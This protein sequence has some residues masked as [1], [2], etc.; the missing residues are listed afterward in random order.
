VELLHCSFIGLDIDPTTKRSY[1]LTEKINCAMALKGYSM[2]NLQFILYDVLDIASLTEKEYFSKHNR[3]NFDVMLEVAEDIADKCLRP[4]FKESDK[5]PPQLINGRVKVHRSLHNYYN[6]FCSAGM[7]AS[8]FDEKLGGSQVPKSVYAAVDFIVGNAHNGY[9]MFTGL[10]V[11]AARLIVSFGSDELI[12]RYASKILSGEWAATMC[13]TEPQAGSALSAI[14]TIAKPNSDGSYKIQGQKIFISGGDHDI[15]NNIVHLVLARIQGA[16][17]GA[18]GISLFVVPLQRVIDEGSLIQNDVVSAGIYHK[19]GQRSTPAM[20]LDFGSNNN[21]FGFLVG[22]QGKGLSYMF[23]MMNTARLGV[24]LAGTYIASFAYY[25]SLQYANERYQ[26]KTTHPR[27]NFEGQTLIINHPDVRRMLF[28]QK[29]IT[30]GSFALVMQCYYYDD[31]LKICE[32]S[33]RQR[34]SD[35]LELLTPVAKTY[36][37]EMGTVSVNNGLQVLGGYGY[38]EDFVLEQLA[39]D[40]RIMSIYEGTTGIQSQALLGREVPANNKR[41]FNLLIAEVT[42]TIKFAQQYD[43][44][45]SYGNWLSNEISELEITTEHLL[46]IRKKGDEEIFL[47]DANLYMEAFGCVCVG[48]QWLNQGIVASRRLKETV[49]DTDKNFLLSKLETMRFFFHYELRKVRGLHERL[50]DETVITVSK[51]DDEILI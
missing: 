50:R 8:T 4:Y 43:G 21:C 10:G 22:E 34:Y 6:T 48:W 35:L 17:E 40:I 45:T 16:Q 9:E 23:Q 11:G 14:R 36:G 37:A 19:M 51:G 5:N 3:E 28:L 39:R 24:G 13:L 30:E 2:R 7:L 12:A 44:L 20:H 33:E 25:A 31:R 42:D 29:A 27:K 47:S 41:S 49:S 26:G 32:S 15:T 46:N 1:G 38:T 18:K